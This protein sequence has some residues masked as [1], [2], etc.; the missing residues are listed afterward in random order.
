VEGRERP[1]RR[2]RL[3]HHPDELDA[4]DDKMR[5]RGN[6]DE[7]DEVPA[8]ELE[9]AIEQLA[10]RHRAKGLSHV[11]PPGATG[12]HEDTS[13][14]PDVYFNGKECYDFLCNS[15]NRRIPV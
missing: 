4:E 13:S 14:E 12:Y 11:E 8:V 5:Q 10:K 9:R 15:S 7:H 1:A 3:Q 2:R 6:A